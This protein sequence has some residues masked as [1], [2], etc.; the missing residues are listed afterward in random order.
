[1]NATVRQTARPPARQPARLSGRF[2]TLE[3]GEGAG[4]STQIARLA[5]YLRGLGHEV[6]TTREPG[7]TPRAQAL[8]EL[9][10]SGKARDL[11]PL[12]EAVIFNAARL[13]HLECLIRPAL[14]RGAV[15]LCD[16]FA[17]STRAYQGVAGDLPSAFVRQMEMAVVGSTTPDL[18]LMLDLPAEAGLARAN[19]RRGGGDVDRFEAEDLTFHDR[20]RQAFLAIAEDEPRRCVVIDAALA[21]EEVEHMIREAVASRFVLAQEGA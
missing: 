17:D 16:R 19:K 6:V 5:T 15:V 7:G 9:V 12:A 2:I 21:P 20:L 4:K 13:D 14:A 11:G 3:G 10:L 8:R 18:T 1:M